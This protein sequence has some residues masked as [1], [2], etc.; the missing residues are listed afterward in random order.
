VLAALVVGL[1]GLEAR[2]QES[3]DAV[4]I[5]G[6]KVGSIHTYVQP[7]KDK[8]RDLLRVRVDL[9]FRFKRLGDPV[10]I[11]ETYGTIET[12][13]GSILRLDTRTLASKGE[14][15]TYGDVV[16]DQMVLTLEGSGQRQQV[17]MAWGPEVRGPYA[18]E[19]SLSRN[20]IKPGET[21][22]LRMYVPDLSK[23]CDVQLV[24]KDKEE[25][26][27]GYGKQALLRVDETVSL[28]GKALPEYTMAHW[29]DTSGQ[30]LK[31][32]GDML[33][34]MEVY[35]TTEEGAKI[36]TPQLNLTL[37]TMIKVTH[38]IDKPESTREVTYRVGLKDEDPTTILPSDR[39]QSLKKDG[40]PNT[41]M[42]VVKTAGPDVGT[43]GPE[44]VDEQFLRPN[45]LVT[46]EDPRVRQLAA[47]AVRD[48]RDP[49]QKAVRITEWVA[50]NIENKNFETAFAPASEVAQ[51]L[52]GDCT[53]HGVLVAAMC[54][55]AGV[56][57]RVVVGLVYVPAKA[58]GGVE[59][60]GFH[61]WDEVYVNRRWV[62]VDAAFN[63]TAVDAVHIK[64]SDTSL[65]GV[66]PYESFLSVVRVLGK[67]TI[68]PVEL[69]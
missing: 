7:V 47:R 59:G 52:A 49:W 4:F 2:A 68:E 67:M 50:K 5:A 31:S 11:K 3:W 38:K 27:L 12:P 33:G 16:D 53:E 35:R 65:D 42:L 30:I 69:R 29:L 54:R 8:G 19:Q 48:A 10:T 25:V 45:A 14:M 22:S 20:L 63:Q 18:V 55:A 6:A 37:S 39:R 51:T 56:P 26:Q 36:G 60:F 21:R 43:A 23:I 34:G 9:E 66:S 41:S 13:D 40:A 64:L 61:M 24:A 15:R 32:K 17:K 1:A 62:A 46:S 57:A 28:N 44:R 58:S